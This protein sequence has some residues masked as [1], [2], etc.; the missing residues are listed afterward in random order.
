MLDKKTICI[1]LDGTIAEFASGWQGEEVFGKPIKNSIQIIKKLKKEGWK[2]I[3]FTTRGDIPL[4]ENYLYIQGIPYDE[5]N[6]NSD[7]PIGTNKGKPIADI[8]IDDRAIQFQGD[9]N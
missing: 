2:I 4:I 6:K 9:W 1:D 8:Y 7:N 3:I 5:I